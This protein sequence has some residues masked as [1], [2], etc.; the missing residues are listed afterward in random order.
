MNPDFDCSRLLMMKLL[1]T[2]LQGLWVEGLDQPITPVTLSLI[3]PSSN[4]LQYH[5]N[6]SEYHHHSFPDDDYSLVETSK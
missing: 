3:I 1:V 2:V 5:H 6:S 4:R